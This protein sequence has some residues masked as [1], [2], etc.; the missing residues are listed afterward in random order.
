MDRNENNKSEQDRQ[1]D[2][3]LDELAKNP[4]TT[5]KPVRPQPPQARSTAH[6]KAPLRSSRTPQRP[7]RQNMDGAPPAGGHSADQANRQNHSPVRSADPAR[8]TFS[9]QDA[10]NASSA[11]GG[12]FRQTFDDIRRRYQARPKK[13]RKKRKPLS[14]RTRRFLMV[15][16][17]LCCIAVLTV[18]IIGGYTFIYMGKNVYGDVIIDLDTQTA[19]QSKTSIVYAY[20]S[21]GNL[22]ELTRLHGQENRIWVD[23]DTI[24]EN[25][26]NAYI[27]LEDKRFRKHHGVDW[28]RTIG[29]IVEY[30]F[31]Q[32]GSTITQQLIKN[33]TGE[34]GRTFS[35]KFNEIIQALNLERH[36]SKN[37]ILEAYLNTL[38][39]DAGCYGVETASEYYFGKE[40]QDLNLAECACIAAITQ[41]PRKYN[42]IINFE[43]NRE[44]QRMC[45]DMMYEQGLITEEEM[46]E[47]KDYEL[48][49]NV[50]ENKVTIDR[51]DEDQQTEEEPNE[52]QS[53]YTDLVID[54][55]I[56]D[57][58]NKYDYTY[59]V[60]ER[61]IYY[62]GLSIY[63]A[64]DLD[65][66]EQLEEVYYNRISFPDDEDIQS[67]MTIMD[68]SGRV[69]AIVGQ[70]GPKP[71]NRCLNMAADSPRQ[72]GSSIKPLS[73]YAPAIN[74]NLITYSTKV[75]NYG[76]MRVDGKIWPYNYGG[77]PGSPNSYRTIQQAIAPSL[78]TVAAQVLEKLGIDT[79]IE[80]M[81]DVFH[82]GHVTESDTAYAPLATGSM[83][84]GTTTLEMAAAYAT[85]GNSGKYY[86]PY[87]YYEVRNS[88]GEVILEPDRDAYEQAIDPGAADVMNELLQ[89]VVTASDG[90]GRR[91]GV[92][93]QVTFAKTGT[94]TDNN[95]SW[96]CGGTPYYVASVWFGYPDSN[97]PLRNIAGNSPSGRVFKEVFDRIHEGLEEKEFEQS[98]SVVRRTYCRGSGLLASSTCA[99]T[100]VGWYKE[101][102]IPG[103][104]TNCGSYGEEEESVQETTQNAPETTKRPAQ[105]TTA[106]QVTEGGDQQDPGDSPAADPTN[107]PTEPPP[108]TAAP[109]EP[110]D[111]R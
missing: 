40:V 101:D 35:R 90:T 84:Y 107:P 96:F 109:P 29:V 89:T 41:A 63:T 85:F 15:F 73:V 42:P 53:Y 95:D 75:Q 37:Q 30:H 8:G 52:Y 83:T 67:A 110:E 61:Q 80:Y 68:Y 77:D 64:V 23:L 87:S 31:S 111:D 59:A 44:R 45:L 10:H 39:L 81:T 3:F 25:L 9:Q 20:D 66:Q 76:I 98:D 7:V 97:R 56:E 108:P 11:H 105:D 60:A 79:S 70:A 6:R 62:G 93:G 82:L 88:E 26:Q 5:A 12:Q 57:L 58:M 38:Y 4:E 28:I 49:F 24:P 47:A 48:V 55:V 50:G 51:D 102:N 22:T 78:N 46:L 106:A 36:Y 69:V 71:G 43:K 1:I 21:G 104:C 17:A 33:L 100:G 19:N 34:N 54:M 27:A 18:G 13:E 74:E 32:G 72:P 2:Q 16:S 94:T 99:S 65:V 103:Y 91:F 86:E 92:D 14:K